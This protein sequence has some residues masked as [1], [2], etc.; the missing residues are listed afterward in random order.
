MES[1]LSNIKYYFEGETS[2]HDLAKLEDGSFEKINV[3]DS[4]TLYVYSEDTPSEIKSIQIA[5]ID[6][7][8]P[9][10]N[11][12]SLSAVYSTTADVNVDAIDNQSGIVRYVLHI[13]GRD[14]IVQSSGE[15][16]IYNLLRDTSYTNCYV[17]VYDEAG[18]VSRSNNFTITTIR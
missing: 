17:D 11:N 8:G 6:K 16:H 9:S 4:T 13:D 2:R 5:N 14:D 15:F 18:N 3:T 1:D 10:I 12:V 7:T